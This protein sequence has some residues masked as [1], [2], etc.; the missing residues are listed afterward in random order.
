MNIGDVIIF[1]GHKYVILDVFTNGYFILCLNANIKAPFHGWSYK[2]SELQV[3]I[4]KWADDCGGR[5]LCR[6]IDLTTMDGYAGFGRMFVKASPLTF[7]EYRKYGRL[8]HAYVPRSKKFW[9]AT[10]LTIRVPQAEQKICTFSSSGLDYA[11]RDDVCDVAPAF[12][13]SNKSL[14]RPLSEYT[15]DELMAELERR[16]K[17]IIWE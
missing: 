6:E 1:H 12:I 10:N 3:T 8:I 13:L 14:L 17:I 7:D 5:V 9:T 2:D 15:D 16:K 11:L 4:N